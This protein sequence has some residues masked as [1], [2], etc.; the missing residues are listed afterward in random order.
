[1]AQLVISTSLD[2]A[3]FREGYAA[4]QQAITQL[5]S[6]PIQIKVDGNFEK[7]TASVAK[8]VAAQEKTKQAV[9]ATRQAH[10]RTAQI[11]A[12]AYVKIADSAKAVILGEQQIQKE[13][14]KTAQVYAQKSAEVRK[15]EEKTAQTAEGTAKAQAK[16]T[17]DAIKAVGNLAKEQEKTAQAQERTKQRALEAAKAVIKG[18]NDAATATQKVADAATRVT[19]AFASWAQR[20]IWFALYNGLRQSLNTMKEMDSYLTTIQRVAG[21]SSE[22]AGKYQE[23]AYDAATKY[24][25]KPAD[26]LANV[27]SFTRAGYGDLAGTLAEVATK[28][29]V[30]GEVSAD[31]ATQMLLATDAAYGFEGNADKLSAVMDGVVA[32][33]DNYATNIEKISEGIGIVASVASVAHV[34]IDELSAAIGTITAT[35]QR[36]GTEAARALRSLFLNI[37]KDTKTEIE[38]GVTWTED[39]IESFQ[40]VLEHF[41][42]DVLRAANEAGKVVNPMEALGALAKGIKEGIINED[43]LVEMVNKLGG[44]LR[45]PQLLS[46]LQNWD[47]YTEQVKTFNDAIGETD[48]KVGVALTS[49]QSKANMLSASFTKLFN[50]VLGS[51]MVKGGLT[52][53][54]ALIDILNAF[55]GAPAKIIAVGTAFTVV[56]KA[57]TSITT[58]GKLASLLSFFTNPAFLAGAGIAA[59]FFGVR[60]AIDAATTSQEEYDEMAQKAS[61]EYQSQQTKVSE[62]TAELEEHKRLIAELEGKTGSLTEAEKSRLEVLRQESQILERNKQIA[63]YQ[64][65]QAARSA[66]T[67][68]AAAGMN[69]A[70]DLSTATALP[71]DLEYF[72]PNNAVQYIAQATSHSDVAQWISAYQI[73][74]KFREQAYKEYN[75][76]SVEDAADLLGVVNSWDGRMTAIRDM[77]VSHLEKQQKYYDTALDY[78]QKYGLYTKDILTEDEQQIRDFIE[79]YKGLSEVYSILMPTLFGEGASGTKPG[80]SSGGTGE[81]GGTGGTGS[82]SSL[83]SYAE[84]QAKVKQQA[85]ALTAAMDENAQKSR[86]T[87]ETYDALTAAGFELKG[88]VM[89]DGNEFVIFAGKLEELRDDILKQCKLWGFDVPESLKTAADE[90]KRSMSEIIKDARSM[91]DEANAAAQALANMQ[92][93]IKDEGNTGDTLIDYRKAYAEAMKAWKAGHYG[94]KN[95]QGFADL[96]LGPEVMASLGY[97]YKEAGKKLSGN[98]FKAL[99]A[100]KSSKDYGL[101]ALKWIEKNI[102]DAKDASGNLLYGFELVNGQ[103]VAAVNDFD[104]LAKALGINKDA[105]LTLFDALGMYKDGLNTTKDDVMD[106]IDGMDGV[107]AS[108]DR[109]NKRLEEIEN[110]KRFHQGNVARNAGD[111]PKVT[112]TKDNIDDLKDW[113]SDTQV[114]DVATLLSQAWGYGKGESGYT[115]VFTP[116]L[117]DGTVMDE[118]AV[119]HYMEETLGAGKKSVEEVLEADAN[120]LNIIQGII[121]GTDDE[122]AKLANRYG[123]LKH[124]LHEMQTTTE[125]TANGIK[126]ID[127]DSFVNNLAAEGQT[128]S[129]IFQML[130]QV[131]GMD[132]VELFGDPGDFADAYEAIQEAV[133]KANSTDFFFDDGQFKQTAEAAKKTLS[134]ITT[135]IKATAGEWGGLLSVDL[136][137]PTV[138]NDKVTEA[139][140]IIETATEGISKDVTGL[141]DVSGT[142]HAYLNTDGAV[143]GRAQIYNISSDLQTFDKLKVD[144]VA[145]M[146]TGNA[147]KGAD[148]VSGI[149][150]LLNS[151]D[152]LDPEAEAKLR[153]DL[154]DPVKAVR[155]AKA[156][157]V[158]FK[159]DYTAKP[160]VDKSK[161]SSD[162]ESDVADA[163]KTLSE[164]GIDYNAVV[165]LKN[166]IGEG[167]VLKLTNQITEITALLVSKDLSVK[168]DTTD[169]SDAQK[170][171]AIKD[172][173][174]LLGDLQGTYTATAKLS[175]LGI[176]AGTDALLTKINNTLD[177][178][179]GAYNAI[180]EISGSALDDKSKAE[181]ITKIKG[182][183]AGLNTTFKVGI[184]VQSSIALQRVATMQQAIAKIKQGAESPITANITNAESAIATIQGKLDALAKGVVI[185]VSIVNARIPSKDVL[186]NGLGGFDKGYSPVRG[187]AETPEYYDPR[188]GKTKPVRSVTTGGSGAPVDLDAMSAQMEA[189]TY[190]MYKKLVSTGKNWASADVSEFEDFITELQAAARSKE[191]TPRDK[192]VADSLTGLFGRFSKEYG[193][194]TYLKTFVSTLLSATG[195]SEPGVDFP[196]RLATELYTQMAEAAAQGD[197]GVDWMNYGSGGQIQDKVHSAYA[198][199][200]RLKMFAGAGN[201]SEEASAMVAEI[202]R[203]HAAILNGTFYDEITGKISSKL[204]NSEETEEQAEQEGQKVGK[205]YA[206]SVGDAATDVN[207]ADEAS[208]DIG[209]AYEGAMSE[210]G[211]KAGTAYATGTVE[212]IDKTLAAG[213]E[214]LARTRSLVSEI[215]GGSEVP[216]AQAEVEGLSDAVADIPTP[217]PLE[218]D[219]SSVEAAGAQVEELS[220][221]IKSIPD[222]TV[223]ITIVYNGRQTPAPYS[224]ADGSPVIS[225]GGGTD[226]FRAR[227]AG[228]RNFAG[229]ISLVN[230]LGPELISAD[231]RAF[232]ANGGAPGIVSLPRGAVIF[233]ADETRSILTGGGIP[234]YAEGNNI[235][236]PSGG[237][238]GDAVLQAFGIVGDALWSGKFDLNPRNDIRPRGNGNGNKNP[239]VDNTDYWAIIEAHYKDVTTAADMT[240][241]NL[242]YQIDLLKNA[243]DDEKK[244]IDEQIEALQDLNKTIDRQIELLGRERDKL[245]EPIQ[246]EVDALKEAKDIQD[247]QLELAE[248]QKAVEEAR[249]ELQNAQNER[250]IRFYNKETGHWEWMA[251]QK[252]IQDAQEALEKAEKSLADYEYD[253][254]IKELEAEIKAIEEDYQSKIDAL[255]ADKQANE[256][257][258]YDLE[259]QLRSIELKYEAL[260]QPLED[261]QTDSDR[262]LAAIKNA[263]SNAEEMRREHAEGDLGNAIAHEGESGALAGGAIKELQADLSTIAAAYKPAQQNNTLASLGIQFGASTGMYNPGNILTSIA[264]SSTDSHNI[265]INGL[266]MPA[267]AAYQSLLEIAGDLAIYA[268]E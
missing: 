94:D 2:Q 161:L 132:S 54:T 35:T 60:A 115:I 28:M 170:Q 205:A 194:P 212:S 42:P 43:E 153:A 174:E 236:K 218:V 149:I 136:G 192:A 238:V 200:N 15:A 165:G 151:Y 32:I 55:D 146:D 40:Q 186:V 1:M 75:E 62:I 265:I 210:A 155:V 114:G 17:D 259:Q 207:A 183:L 181:E 219:D 143:E 91:A 113:N 12:Q 176:N 224:S 159:G 9:E 239:P 71:S 59:A 101:E 111:R 150:G 222:K 63:D 129:Q 83:K 225:A 37:I 99:F 82:E 152:L 79:Y 117:P 217:E 237:S 70:I 216:D 128:A 160:G 141:D 123:Q 204:F 124:E 251:D 134:E 85:E 256:D 261:Q 39:E 51:G 214:T 229:G 246:D 215:M 97:S 49:W 184:Q 223:T 98:F 139:E 198:N 8:V 191:A 166:K 66:A 56:S 254:H 208:E 235:T 197:S 20:R 47:M 195:G 248:R 167:E 80:E 226:L 201:M 234:A 118:D 110:N 100:P 145:E 21:V 178:F 244:P 173:K 264:G 135:D 58:G 163:K 116:I 46:L 121:E 65:E 96:V 243:W 38:D 193:D 106:M 84:A 199:A 19:E 73:A 245:T 14:E 137:T 138:N 196:L 29:Q 202:G 162:W 266:T 140:G 255:N 25:V 88:A 157:L 147:A 3:G 108:A 260:I 87:K 211:E 119:K 107:A 190:G 164:Y 69:S 231:G 7:V 24:G 262:A 220:G 44:K 230:E 36:S 6:K 72:T 158:G 27:V 252:R 169:L 26:Y 221:D 249:A 105:L 16:A 81:A 203:L 257:T 156:L 172:A 11:A 93:G 131:R 68:A 122:A 64:A 177:T 241:E 126:R 67:A 78:A 125:D 50:N 4:L 171:Q 5:S 142:A 154:A 18:S 23:Q 53:L 179:D 74:Q 120:G 148:L 10:E 13:K 61:Q 127:F 109:A 168:L 34:G 33:G 267:S 247:D 189:V 52:S 103:V 227:A 206:E 242:K 89:Q 57:I 48:S 144:A 187:T 188:T 104:A 112:A 41:I 253:L 268:G 95:L 76:A 86:I 185:P 209:E 250:T 130:K 213:E 228:D 77:L 182:D 31:V 22:A 180:V 240:L 232:I 258:I 90:A 45:S 92:K 263:W 102:V 133:K 233:T 30:V 175:P